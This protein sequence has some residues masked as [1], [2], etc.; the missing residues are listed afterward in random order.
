MN[1]IVIT[2][3]R[4]SAEILA[5]AYAPNGH[6]VQVTMDTGNALRLARQLTEAATRRLEQ[7]VPR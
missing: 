2:D 3:D 4:R 6:L 7:G 5:T 1:Q